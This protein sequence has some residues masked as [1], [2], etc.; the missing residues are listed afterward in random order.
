MRYCVVMGFKAGLCGLGRTAKVTIQQVTIF[1]LFVGYCIHVGYSIA[2]KSK[3]ICLLIK[4]QNNT[5]DCEFTQ[6]K[7]GVTP[8]I[9]R[10][11]TVR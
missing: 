8:K 6:N 9:A 10:E 1:C 3:A 2:V 4:V 5:R 11:A 7:T